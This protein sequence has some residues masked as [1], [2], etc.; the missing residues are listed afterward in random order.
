MPELPTAT[1]PAVPPA[2]PASWPGLGIPA[3]PD[4]VLTRVQV[5]RSGENQTAGTVPEL[6]VARPATT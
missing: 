4:P 3:G 5:R 2:T 1:K 6:A